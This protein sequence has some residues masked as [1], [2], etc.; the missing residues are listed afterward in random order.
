[1]LTLCVSSEAIIVLTR[2]LNSQNSYKQVQQLL[3]RSAS[4]AQLLAL[5]PRLTHACSA[6]HRLAAVVSS[7]Y[8]CYS[9]VPG[10]H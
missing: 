7:D 5:L 8:K 6:L 1:M 9:K 2:T 4:Q 10:T 3:F